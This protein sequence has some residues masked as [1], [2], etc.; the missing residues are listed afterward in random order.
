[1]SAILCTS[2]LSVSS[3]LDTYNNGITGNSIVCGER[4]ILV[5]A[6]ENRMLCPEPDISCA[7]CSIIDLFVA[8]SMA[9]QLQQALATPTAKAN[10]TRQLLLRSLLRAPLLLASGQLKYCQQQR[11]STRQPA[12]QSGHSTGD[13]RLMSKLEPLQHHGNG[14]RVAQD[15]CPGSAT[16]M[17]ANVAHVV[18]SS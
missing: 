16:S 1:M 5:S 18:V 9:L 6:A 12:S 2:P 3:K 15:L 13:V 17:V 10:S 8:C 11:Q 4:I 7:N 14:A